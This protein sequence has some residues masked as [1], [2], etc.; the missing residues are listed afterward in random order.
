VALSIFDD[1]SHP[2]QPDE[3]NRI[4]G[5]TAKLW[6]AIISH[7]T[8]SY[9]PI[10]EQWNF[11]GGKY[12]WSLRLK[13][14]DRVIIYLTPQKDQFLVGIVLGEKAAEAAHENGLPQAVLNLI[15]AAPKYTEGRG[16]RIRVT[17][18]DEVAVVKKLVLLK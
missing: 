9:S 10:T 6:Q 7:V 11:A 3:I 13:V 16:I 4:L 15:D 14:K 5:S 18:Q 1:K 17:T 2:P 8:E 12:G